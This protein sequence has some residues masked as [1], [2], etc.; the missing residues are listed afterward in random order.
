METITQWKELT[1]KSLS[2]MGEKIMTAL[3][4][5]IGA[6]LILLLGW[7]VTKIIIFLLKRVL[8]F[9]KID[10]LTAKINQ[11]KL[12]GTTD[13]KF[14]ITNAIVIFVKWIMFLVFLIIASDIMDWTIVSEE[15]GNLLRYLPKL[16]SA[17]ALFMIG[18]YIAKFVKK[19]IQGFYESFDLA[20]SKII[21]TLVFYIIAVIITITALNQAGIDTTVVTNNVTVILGAFLLAISIGFGLGSKDVI[22]DLLRTFYTRKNYEIGDIVKIKDIEGSVESIDNICMTLNTKSGKIILPIKDV[23]ENQVEIKKVK[24]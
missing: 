17:I 13:I 18:I 23:V 24:N 20:G 16:F 9:V 3:P 5:I 8:K 10:Q 22:G 1:F 21:S 11:M 15:I 6:I 19:A 12:F 7:I 2:A 14:G 4:N